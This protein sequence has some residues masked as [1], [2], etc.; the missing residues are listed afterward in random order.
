MS[1]Y[2]YSLILESNELRP[3][4]ITAHYR[5]ANFFSEMSGFKFDWETSCLRLN[6]SVL[7]QALQEMH[8]QFCPI[9][10]LSLVYI[11]AYLRSTFKIIWLKHCH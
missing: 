8:T 1:S 5:C 7:P 11:Q 3:E 6:F 4:T 2:Q 9:P 10:N